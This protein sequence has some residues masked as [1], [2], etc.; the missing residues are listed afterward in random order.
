MALNPIF[1]ALLKEFAENQ[2][3]TSE[4]QSVQFE[5]FVNF[6]VISDVYGE[7]FNPVDI[8]TGNDEFGLDGIAILVNGMLVEDEDQV[9]ELAARNKYL[10]VEFIF[11]QAKTSPS[12]DGGDILKTMV[13]VE[14]FFGPLQLLRGDRARTR[15]ALKNYIYEKAQLFRRGNPSVQIF[16][17]TTGAWKNEAGLVA[18]I[19]PQKEKLTERQIFSS[20]TV[21]PIGATELQSLYFRTKNAVRQQIAFERYVTLPMIA[22]VQEAH[23]GVLPIQEYLKLVTD[24][25]GSLRRQIFFDNMRDFMQESATN[26]EIAETLTS[27]R[28]S[29][30]PLRN[31]GI[32]IVARKLQRVGNLF[33]LE[34]YQIVNGCQTSHVIFNHRES[35]SDAV[36]VPVKIIVTEQ[37]D[38]VNKIIRGSNFSNQFDNSQLWATEPFH[39]DLEVYFESLEG[40]RKLYYERRKGQFSAAAGVEKV[41]IVT[42]IALLKAAS[43]IYLERAHDVTKYYSALAPEVGKT[44]FVHGQN[45]IA[46][47]TAAYAAYRLEALFRSKA[48]PSVYK[49]L[50]Y[51]LLMGAK[52]T[53]SPSPIRLTDKN[54]GKT[55]DVLMSTLDDPAKAAAMFGELIDEADKVKADLRMDSYAQLAKQVALRDRIREFGKRKATT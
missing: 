21:R 11:T 45:P 39:K 48:L 42:P 50:R 5:H 1:A 35:L 51:H 17:V 33:D 25:S 43:S 28:S 47:Q 10:E 22:D 40:E 49:P 52:I 31:N 26:I 41:R 12:F 16:Y 53:S 36:V 18:L 37:D 27:P 2:G 34:D 7:E 55:L 29:E 14:D 23:I 46:Y 13:A 32:T 44:V 24:E 15:F 30:F 9:D 8:S 3:I 6:S 54:V 38:V 20:V 19:E 4:E